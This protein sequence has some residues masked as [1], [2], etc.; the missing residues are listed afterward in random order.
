MYGLTRVFVR[1]MVGSIPLLMLVSIIAFVLMRLAPGDPVAMYLSSD[2]G[3]ADAETIA[4][5]R[6]YLGLNQPLHAQYWQWLRRI[7]SGDLGYSLMTRRP[8]A[9]MIFEVL[10]NTLLLAGVS[11]VLAVSTGIVLGV[12]TALRRRTLF[13]YVITAGVFVGYSV[14]AFSLGLLLL[15][16]FSFELKLL[17]S[18]GMRSVRDPVASSVVDV[19]RHSILPV[20]ATTVEQ[21]AVWVRYQRTAF[22]DVLS[23]DYLRTARAK[24]LRESVVILRHAWRNSLIPIVTRLGL[25]FS[26]LVGGSF[27]IESVFAWPGM[28]SLGMEAIRFRDYPVSMG[29]VLISSIM[30]ILGNLVADISYVALDPRVRLEEKAL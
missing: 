27:I 26:T 25:S 5:I 9:V 15:Y 16:L 19:L 18:A 2:M 8:V 17:P 21:L 24:G 20:L 22:I 23:Q 28:G 6:E 4:R 7:A 29:I 30:I 3:D 13:D 1:R 12:A 11:L 14:P 10:P